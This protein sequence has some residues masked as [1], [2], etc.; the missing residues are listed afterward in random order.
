[1]S[2]LLSPV[3]EKPLL[4]KPLMEKNL[5]TTATAEAQN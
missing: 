1:M 4:Q 5:I 2:W 3:R